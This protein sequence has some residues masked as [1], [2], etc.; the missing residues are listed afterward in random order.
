AGVG[1]DAALALGVR[2]V[3]VRDGLCDRVYLEHETLGFDQVERE[4][5]PRFRPERV[6]AIT[7]IPRTDIE[8]LAH[9]Y[10]RARAPFIRIGWGMSRNARGGQAI[11]TIALLPGVT[12]AYARRGG[13]ALLSTPPGFGFSFAAIRRPSGPPEART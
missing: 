7:D 9:L 2:H 5:L 12:G 3:L 1:P 13:G 4:V 8:R 11:R 6:E 10:G